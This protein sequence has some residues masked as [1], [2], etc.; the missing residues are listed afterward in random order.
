MKVAVIIAAYNCEKYILE[1]YKSVKNQVPCNGWTYEIR[2]GIDN[3]PR[4]A[5]ICRKHNI[6]FYWSENNVG[7][8]VMRNSLIALLPADKY[9]IFDAD[10]AMYPG[11]LIKSLSLSAEAVMTAKI[12]CN[13]NLTPI[14]SARIEYGGA[15]TFSHKLL[16]DL[17][18]F[19]DVR[20]AADSNFMQRLNMAGYTIKEILEPLYFRRKHKNSLTIDKNTGIGSEYRRN[21]YRQMC[22]KNSQG[23]IK[24]KPTTAPLEYINDFK[25]LQNMP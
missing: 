12:N 14:Q 2:L 24:I 20:C 16:S 18:G 9:A 1:C 6:P 15:M 19:Y 17:G 10:D 23:I 3:C 8:Y 21:V 5:D 11:Y 25:N 7:A 13:E 22:D 4:T